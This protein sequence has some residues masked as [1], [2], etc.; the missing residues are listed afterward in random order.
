MQQQRAVTNENAGTA[1]G[2]LLHGIKWNQTAKQIQGKIRY[3]TTTSIKA[4]LHQIAEYHRV[5]RKQKHRLQQKPT[6][7][8]HRA[9]GMLGQVAQGQLPKGVAEPPPFFDVLYQWTVKTG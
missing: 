4:H 5:N 7:T 6:H 1:H 3:P 8:Q 2:G 9:P